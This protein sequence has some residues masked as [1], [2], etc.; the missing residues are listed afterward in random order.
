M[1]PARAPTDCANPESEKQTNRKLKQGDVFAAG[2]K[3]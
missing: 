2:K 1:Q 3:Q